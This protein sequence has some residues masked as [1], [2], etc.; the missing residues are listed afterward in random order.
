MN[1][2]INLVPK[3][4]AGVEQPSRPGRCGRARVDN[5]VGIDGVRMEPVG[6]R[7]RGRRAYDGYGGE[8]RL[9]RKPRGGCDPAGSHGCTLGRS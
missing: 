6:I 2:P 5:G 9:R 3:P 8:D 1:D 4:R 7:E